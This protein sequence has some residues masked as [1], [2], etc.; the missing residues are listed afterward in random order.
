MGEDAGKILW[1]EPFF[2][3]GKIEICWIFSRTRFF[4]WIFGFFVL[5]KWF[6]LLVGFLIVSADFLILSAYFLILSTGTIRLSADSL[7][8]SVNILILL[9]CEKGRAPGI[10]M[11]VRRCAP[12]PVQKSWTFFDSN[13]KPLTPSEHLL[14]EEVCIIRRWN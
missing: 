7:I 14:L 11:N 13:K 1:E 9:F 6:C 8:V 3:V 4:L 10:C 12:S 2:C 5:E